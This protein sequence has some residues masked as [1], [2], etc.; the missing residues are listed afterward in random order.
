MS[1]SS[2]PSLAINST[3]SNANT[4]K[5]LGQ[6]KESTDAAARSLEQ[7]V[8][9][10]TEEA[11]KILK[12]SQQKMRS[13]KKRFCKKSHLLISILLQRK[14]TVLQMILCFAVKLWGKEP[15]GM[16]NKGEY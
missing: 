9:E 8:E 5:C 3:S 4:Q 12:Q 16:E 11:A 7:Q 6:L 13:S 14:N 2:T 1:I 10:A 15:R